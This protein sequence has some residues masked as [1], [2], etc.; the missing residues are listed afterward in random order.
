MKSIFVSKT[1]WVNAVSGVVAFLEGQQVIDLFSAATLPYVSAVVFAL[2]IV[3]RYV[4]TAAVFIT[5]VNTREA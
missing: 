2:N 4:T 5:P 3:L 1:F